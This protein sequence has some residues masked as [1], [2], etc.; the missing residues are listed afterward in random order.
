MSFKL[1][2]QLLLGKGNWFAVDEMLA[3]FGEVIGN[4]F[5]VHCQGREKHLDGGLVKDFYSVFG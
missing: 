3:G 5:V 4:C 1:K 2:V